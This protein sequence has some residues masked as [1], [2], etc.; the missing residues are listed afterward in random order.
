MD[1]CNV[2]VNIAFV[3][4]WFVMDSLEVLDAKI[5]SLKLA[6]SLNIFIN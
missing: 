2:S 1:E 5:W 4:C 3:I 6:L